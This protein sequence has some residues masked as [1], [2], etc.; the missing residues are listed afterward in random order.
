MLNVS[1]CVHQADSAASLRSILQITQVRRAFSDAIYKCL[2]LQYQFSCGLARALYWMYTRRL[3]CYKDGGIEPH[4]VAHQ[5]WRRHKLYTRLD[6]YSRH[7]RYP[8]PVCVTRAAHVLLWSAHGDTLSPTAPRSRT[9]AN[10][11]S[12]HERRDI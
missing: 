11:P 3:P 2:L 5:N 9:R 4:A 6:V 1:T 12:A 8:L 7:S 10:A